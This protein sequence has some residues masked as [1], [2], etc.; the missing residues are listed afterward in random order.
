MKLY[1]GNP[2]VMTS[3]RVS[4]EFYDKCKQHHIKFSEAI[5]RGIALMLAERGVEDYDNNLNI[6]RLLNEYKLKAAEALQKIADL[7]NE[8]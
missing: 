4:S 8:S 3:V 2:S 1:S 6:V 5:R 7:E